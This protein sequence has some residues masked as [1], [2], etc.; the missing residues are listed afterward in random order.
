MLKPLTL[1]LKASSFLPPV[2]H[3]LTTGSLLALS[4][5]SLL[6]SGLKKWKLNLLRVWAVLW[7]CGNRNHPQ[8]LILPLHSHVLSH[9]WS[10]VLSLRNFHLSP[11]PIGLRTLAPV[12]SFFPLVTSEE[13]LLTSL[14]KGQSIPVYLHHHYLGPSSCV[15]HLD[16]SQNLAFPSLLLPTSQQ[17]PTQW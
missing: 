5:L 4:I 15:S 6:F 17:S 1:W 9:V 2:V 11:Q 7:N 13:V 10:H 3:L 8:S 16:Y 12:F 14:S